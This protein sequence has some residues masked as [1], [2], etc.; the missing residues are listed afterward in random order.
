MTHTGHL[1]LDALGA[2]AATGYTRDI[3]PVGQDDDS[4]RGWMPN[5]TTLPGRGSS[6][7]G[8]YATA[9][10][11]VRFAQALRA[12]R[13]LD[14]EHVRDVFGEH[15]ALGIAGGSPGVNALFVVV[16]PYTLVVLANFDPPTAE[17]FAPTV[18]RM[19]RRAAGVP[20]PVRR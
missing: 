19:L 15:F 7:G 18:G 17:R 20:V 5:T 12:G 6:A 4:L 2:D 1:A 16:G 14:A 9:G 13:L 10:D 11:L 8:G 3:A